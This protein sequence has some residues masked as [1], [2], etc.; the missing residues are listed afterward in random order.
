[1]IF[2][3][4]GQFG[5]LGLEMTCMPIV[6]APSDQ[7]TPTRQVEKARG[8]P[9][10][11]GHW[12]LGTIPMRCHECPRWKLATQRGEWGGG[13]QKFC[14]VTGLKVPGSFTVTKFLGVFVRVLP[15]HVRIKYPISN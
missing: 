6:Q 15:G 14:C 7:C 4:L 8:K 1:M 11:P 12:Y 9:W 3:T 10:H 13:G 5:L 2:S